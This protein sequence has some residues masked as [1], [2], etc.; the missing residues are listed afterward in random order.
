[1]TLSATAKEAVT[2]DQGV[3]GAVDIDLNQDAISGLAL[4]A[5]ARH[6]V[7]IIEMSVLVYGQPHRPSRVQADLELSLVVDVL[8]GPERSISRW[9]RRSGA[10]TCIRSPILHTLEVRGSSPPTTPDDTRT[11]GHSSPQYGFSGL[12]ISH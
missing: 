1:M 2:D 8:E 3:G 4:A 6:S 5:G 12:C 7:A 11:A 10:V 9:R